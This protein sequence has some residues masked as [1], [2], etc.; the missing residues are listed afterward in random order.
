M[1]VLSIFGFHRLQENLV[2]D[3]SFEHHLMQ[4][5]CNFLELLNIY[6]Y[7]KLLCGFLGEKRH[8]AMTQNAQILNTF[9]H[10]SMNNEDSRV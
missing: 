1:E 9:L 7:Y 2:I 3:D 10:I 6:S 5:A 4:K 8:L